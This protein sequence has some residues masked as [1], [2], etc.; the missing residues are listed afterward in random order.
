MFFESAYLVVQNFKVFSYL[1]IFILSI[2]RFLFLEHSLIPCVIT[3]ILL[4][5]SFFFLMYSFCVYNP[6]LSENFLDYG[7]KLFS[8][9]I[10]LIVPSL[11]IGT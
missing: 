3:W 4:F 11:L 9:L 7:R 8:S 5:T 10:A 2:I 6:Y 1:N